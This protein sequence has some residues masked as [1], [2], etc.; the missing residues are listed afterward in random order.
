MVDQSIN[1]SKIPVKI[2]KELIKPLYL[3]K[4]ILTQQDCVDYCNGKKKWDEFKDAD[5][6]QMEIDQ[7]QMQIEELK[8]AVV[9]KADKNGKI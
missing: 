1:Q 6:L 3:T 4:R 7:Q 5:Y 8:Q 2:S 9:K